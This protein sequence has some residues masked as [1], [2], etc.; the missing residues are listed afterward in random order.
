VGANVTRFIF[1]FGGPVM[2]PEIDARMV[3]P[4]SCIL[5]NFWVRSTLAPGVGETYDLTVLLNGAPTLLTLQIAGAVAVQAGPD[6]DIVAIVAG[7]EI[8]VEI[9]SSLNAALCQ[10]SWSI[11]CRH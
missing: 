11:E 1:P 9:V 7:D 4:F 8:D 3:M 10:M 2:V 6:L 5:T